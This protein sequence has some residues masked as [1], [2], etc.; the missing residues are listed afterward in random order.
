MVFTNMGPEERSQLKFIKPASL[1]M[2]GA[3]LLISLKGHISNGQTQER[4]LGYSFIEGSGSSRL[5]SA[6]NNVQVQRLLLDIAHAPRNKKYL[7]SKL[8]GIQINVKALMDLGLVRH[9][10]DLYI[11]SFLLFSRNDEHRMREITESHARM[12]ATAILNRRTEIEEVIKGYQLPG[13]DPR[14]VLYIILGCFSLDWDGLSLNEKMGHWSRPSLFRRLFPR[15]IVYAWHPPKLSPELSRRGF[16]KGSH[17]TK[18]GKST[19]ASFGD[20]EIQPRHAFPDVLWD[21]SGYPDTLKLKMK[22]IIGP[23]S[24]K[25]VG[26]QVAKLMSA[27]REGEMNLAELAKAAGTSE[28]Q[29]KELAD[30]LV[31]L[32]YISKNDGKYSARIPVMTA[33][34]SLIVQRIRRIGREELERWLELEYPQLRKELKE[35]TPFRYGVAQSGLFYRIWHD[36]FGAANRMLVESGFYANPY[37]KSYGAKGI[38]PAVFDSSLY[39]KP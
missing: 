12:L 34:D 28:N 10:E 25:T 7:E 5:R 33:R 39:K 26:K 21:Q 35:L 32:L 30:F 19:L 18:Y 11:I 2:L 13:V 24:E 9:Q 22:G 6:L 27:L 36:I 8:Q 23:T 14:A 37:S 20:H 17:S 31:D 3:I 16:Y 38:I 4:A 1:L 15:T 29:T